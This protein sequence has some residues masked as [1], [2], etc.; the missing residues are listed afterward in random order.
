VKDLV[1]VGCGGHGR[2]LFDTVIAANRVEPT[3]RVLGFVDDA[4]SQPERL[5]RLGAD[6]LG[7]VEWLLD[8]PGAYA[9]GIGTSAVR[10]RLVERFDDAGLEPTTVVHPGAHIGSDVR[11]APGVVVYD[12]CTVTTNV[13]VGRHTHLNVACAVQ[14]DSTIGEFVQL[15]PGVLVNGDCTVGD[16]TSLGTGA[17]VTRGRSVGAGARI[18]AGAVVL[19][20]VAAGTTVVG[21]PARR[22]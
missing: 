18:G 5:Q 7:P 1:I 3:W 12:R 19:D 16:R 17:I 10:A 21:V 22:S 9:L 2:E 4:P 8:H 20:D 11:L 15:S 13:E 6:L 14:H